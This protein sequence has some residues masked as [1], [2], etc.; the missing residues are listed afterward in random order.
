MV[1]WADEFIANYWVI[2]TKE[3]PD[4]AFVKM[5]PNHR[6]DISQPDAVIKRLDLK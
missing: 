5:M 3:A 6:R 1:H 2:I 4:L